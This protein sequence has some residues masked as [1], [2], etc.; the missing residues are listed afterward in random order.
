MDQDEIRLLNRYYIAGLDFD[1]AAHNGWLLAA[2]CHANQPKKRNQIFERGKTL[3]RNVANRPLQTLF[4]TIFAEQLWFCLK[5]QLNKICMKEALSKIL[6]LFAR[7]K[8][9]V[10][11]LLVAEAKPK[12]LTRLRIWL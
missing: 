6:Q 11:N 4:R 12:T 2:C 5:A 1:R 8:R 3:K 7:E 9:I 10:S